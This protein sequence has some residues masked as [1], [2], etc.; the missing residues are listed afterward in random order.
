MMEYCLLSIKSAFYAYQ[1]LKITLLKIRYLQGSFSS[2]VKI[3]PVIVSFAS[4][5]STPDSH[6]LPMKSEDYLS[7][8][9]HSHYATRSIMLGISIKYSVALLALVEI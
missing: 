1:E 7:Q 5:I 2:F 4:T 3:L 6:Y 8:V 9:H